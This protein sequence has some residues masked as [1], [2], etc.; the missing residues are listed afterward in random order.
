VPIDGS[1][2]VLLASDEQRQDL[3]AGITGHQ[4]L[5]PADVVQRVVAAMNAVIDRYRV[6][7]GFTCLAR[8]ADQLYADVLAERGL[9][10]CVII[11]SANYSS[12]FTSASDR[13]RFERLLRLASRT[14]ALPFKEASE[15]AFYEAGKR[16]VD[17]SEAII[18][19]WDGQAAKGLGG[20]A[21]IVA[22]ALTAGRMVIQI[23]PVSGQVVEL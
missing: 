14:I 2:A 1:R 15:L 19:A 11:P 17:M 10:Y 6:N 8:G 20:T 12:L 9:P 3:K 21:D 22:Y 16:V 4:E 5:G 18:A 7:E 13:N 23:E